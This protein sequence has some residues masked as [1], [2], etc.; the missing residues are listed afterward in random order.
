VQQ[1]D[2]GTHAHVAETDDADFHDR[3]LPA[4]AKAPMP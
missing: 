3:F 4:G 2:R 1:I